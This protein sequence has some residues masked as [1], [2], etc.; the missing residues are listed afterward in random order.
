MHETIRHRA[1]QLTKHLAITFRKMFT[2]ILFVALTTKQNK[3]LQFVALPIDFVTGLGK[4]RDASRSWGDDAEK[5]G[6][7]Y[8]PLRDDEWIYADSVPLP[9]LQLANSPQ[10]EQSSFYQCVLLSHCT[11]FHR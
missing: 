2:F 1:T 11:Q 5:R 3:S 8:F 7:R 6:A 4:G 9:L 10:S